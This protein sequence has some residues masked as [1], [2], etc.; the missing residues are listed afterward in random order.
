MPLRL[1][2]SLAGRFK[3]MGEMNAAQR[4]V[5]QDGRFPV[6]WRER[7]FDVRVASCPS[8]LG[9]LVVMRLID[10]RAMSVRLDELQFGDA[11]LGRL[12]EWLARPN[13]L[14]LF[15]GPTGSGKTTVLYAALL[16]LNTPQKKIITIEDPVEWQLPGVVQVA[17]DRRAGLTYASALRS[18]L[19]QDPDIIMAGEL[20]DVESADTAA[21]AALAGTT[22]LSTLHLNNAIE[23]AARLRDL[24]VEPFL[25]SASLTGMMSQRLARRICAHCRKENA[26]L[27]AT[28]LKRMRDLAEEGGY[29]VAN[30][31]KF[32]RGR[33]CEKCHN[34]GFR[35]RVPI[36]ELVIWSAALSEAFLR[37]A[38]ADEMTRIAVYEG[39]TTML[40]DGIRKAVAGHTTPEE[41]L[42]V[43]GVAT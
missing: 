26:P 18:F 21:Q 17:V 10:R 22:V 24:G 12:Q 33:G 43:L 40:A 42:R 37:G 28:F 15:C 32:A 7:E 9:E 5:P 39:T 3:V 25:I 41:V 35:G 19:R 2:A 20:R 14:V 16:H 11:D 27:D 34:T 6:K 4:D 8:S 36:Y 38:P 1:L 31:A 13:G 30:K 29:A 23:A